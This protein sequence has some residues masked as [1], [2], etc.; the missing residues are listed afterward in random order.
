MTSDAI[1]ASR[2]P[3]VYW[4]CLWLVGLSFAFVLILQDIIA[5]DPGAPPGRDFANLYN[6]GKLALD[7]YAYRAFDVDTFRFGF[8]DLFGKFIQ[9]NY[10]YPPH[11]LLLAA[12]MAMLPYW[13]SFA[14]WTVVSV[15][16]FYWAAKPHVPFAPALAVLTPAAAI[17]IWNGH[18]GLLLGALWLL[19]FQMRGVKAG[20]IASAM[21]IKPHMGLFIA[22]TA[23]RDWRTV[24]AAVC[25][26]IALVTLS[27]FLFE[28]ASWYGF[29]SNT[30]GVQ[31]EMLTRQKNDFYFR[32]MPSAYTSFGRD[33]GAIVIHL[34]FAAV[35]AALVLRSRRID[36]FAFATAT[37][38]IVPYVFIYDMTVA[39]LGFAMILW[40]DWGKLGRSEKVVLTLAFMT[41]NLTLV[42][43]PLTGPIL[44]AA[45]AVQT[46]ADVLIQSSRPRRLQQ[47]KI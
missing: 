14:V 35:A 36:P 9:Q 28:P 31:M 41:P 8:L 22:I 32:L 43:P 39:C 45:L 34:L 42:F 19:F 6:A 16:L 13:P 29:I 2:P 15:G 7:G 1:S 21:T 33:G 3:F 10:S 46:K 12:P 5:P 18:Y 24:A 44:L 40:R 20:L 4:T 17:N 25:G 23:L 37:F 27:I 38:L 47:S 30:F 11:A 26:T